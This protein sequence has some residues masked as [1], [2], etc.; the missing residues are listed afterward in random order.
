MSIPQ[1]KEQDIQRA[2]LQYLALRGALAW[3]A[4]SGAVTATYKGKSRFFRFASIDGLSDIVAAIPPDGR[5]ACIE[6]KRPGGRLSDK[7]RSFLAAAQ[8]AGVLAFVATSVDDVA[9]KLA[10]EGY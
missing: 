1:P 9:A 8:S 5:M 6:V 4:N 2:I 10:A 7:Q 3:R